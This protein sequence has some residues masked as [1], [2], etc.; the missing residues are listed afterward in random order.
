VKLH[1]R[2]ALTLRARRGQATQEEF[3][4]RLGVS[5]ATLTRLENGAQNTTLRTLEQLA[6]ALHCDVADLF[7]LHD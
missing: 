3:A 2:L 7:R 6:R 5:R 4:R 1:R